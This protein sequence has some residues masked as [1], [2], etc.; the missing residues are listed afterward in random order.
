M[1]ANSGNEVVRGEEKK[2]APHTKLGLK[3]DNNEQLTKSISQ[4]QF[5]P[6]GPQGT[7]VN[8]PH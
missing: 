4:L 7:P 2:N 6:T 3:S 1:I 8:R 5:N